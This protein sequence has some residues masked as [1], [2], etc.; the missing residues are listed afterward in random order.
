MQYV[1]FTVRNN[2]QL[3]AVNRNTLRGVEQDMRYAGSAILIFEDGTK[4]EIKEDFQTAHSRLN[5]IA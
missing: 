1:L 4:L 2:G 3:I 5:T